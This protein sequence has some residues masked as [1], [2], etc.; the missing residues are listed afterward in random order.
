M[1]EPVDERSGQL[2]VA[3]HRIPLRKLK[4]GGDDKA[5]LFAAFRNGLKEQFGR[6][7]VQRNETEFVD[8]EQLNI[9]SVLRKALSCHFL[10]FSCKVPAS[11]VAV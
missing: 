8:Y 7:F 5:A 4:V 6:L 11:P 1:N 2:V 3:K 10:L 9:L